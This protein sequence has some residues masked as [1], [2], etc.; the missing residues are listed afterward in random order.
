[1]GGSAA[2]FDEESGYLTGG[3]VFSHKFALKR[4]SSNCLGNWVNTEDRNDLLIISKLEDGV[5]CQYTGLDGYRKF[6]RVRLNCWRLSASF[7]LDSLGL[8][9][10]DA[11]TISGGAYYENTGMMTIEIFDYLLN[12]AKDKKRIYLRAL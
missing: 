10:L 4:P 1:M 11:T 8:V 7:V 5:Y 9:K 12:K 2:F 6:K 3:A